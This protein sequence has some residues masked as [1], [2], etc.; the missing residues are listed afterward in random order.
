MF[1]NAHIPDDEASRSETEDDG[2]VFADPVAVGPDPDVDA[3]IVE[4]DD[5]LDELTISPA[6]VE[7]FERMT[8]WITAREGSY[9]SLEEMR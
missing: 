9:V 6:D 5:G 7:G 8:T 4:R 3:A 1:D 2:G